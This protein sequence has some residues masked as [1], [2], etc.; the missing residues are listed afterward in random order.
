M[1]YAQVIGAIKPEFVV[2]FN[3]GDFDHPFMVEKAFRYGLLEYFN[4]HMACFY[5]PTKLWDTDL[6]NLERVLKHEPTPAEKEAFVNIKLMGLEHRGRN[7]FTRSGPADT[8]QDGVQKPR[9]P[10]IIIK[11]PTP[12][13]IVVM[14]QP[15]NERHSELLQTYNNMSTLATQRGWGMKHDKVK[16]DPD[17][18]GD[19]YSFQVP[20]TINV[21]AR[22]MFRALYKNPE[23]SSLNWFLQ[24][25]KLDLKEDM[26]IVELFR[27]YREMRDAIRSNNTVQQEALMAD[28]ERVKSYCVTDSES[29]HNLMLK[30]KVVM[31][32]RNTSLLAFT[33]MFD[34]IYRADGMKVR[35]LT[36]HDAAE[37]DIVYSG[38]NKS[39]ESTAKYPG[40]Y[41]VP[42]EKG[43][44]MSKLSIAERV[45]AGKQNVVHPY[46][47]RSDFSRWANITDEDV[48]LLESLVPKYWRDNDEVRAGHIEIQDPD[49]PENLRPLFEDFINDLTGRPTSGLD[50]SSLYPSVM[51]AYNFSPECTIEI[52]Y[53]DP[54]GE[55]NLE[56][57]AD[58]LRA[59][60]YELHSVEFPY[61]DADNVRTIR[62]YT[63]R[64][65][66]D[67]T[68][69]DHDPEERGFGVFPTILHRLFKQRKVIKKQMKKYAKVMEDTG[70]IV[71]ECKKLLQILTDDPAR[72]TDLLIG[73]VEEG[74]VASDTT[75]ATLVEALSSKLAETEKYIV[76]KDYQSIVFDY[77]Y[78]N[79]KQLA[80]KVFMNTFYGE[81]GNKRSSLFM[82]PVSGGIT[83]SGQYNIKLVIGYVEQQKCRVIYGDTDSAYIQCPEITYRD[84]DI[85]YYSGQMTKLEYW[86][87][88]VKLTFDAI[89]IIKNKTNAILR[90]DNLTNF[91][92][93][94]YE[95]VL[96]PVAFLAKKKYY[97]LPHE[98]EINF[99]PSE[100]F[101]KGFDMKK[102]GVPKILIKTCSD[103]MWASLNPDEM[104]TLRGIV[105]D[106]IQEVHTTTWEPTDFEQT[107][108]YKPKK[109]NVKVQTFVRRMREEREIEMKPNERFKYVL[110][111]K[112]AFRWDT[113]GRT[114][115]ATKGDLM[116]LTE[117]ATAEQMEIDLR[118]YM[119]GNLK[120]QFGRLIIYHEEF[121]H[122]VDME[123]PYKQRERIIFDNACREVQRLCERYEDKPVNAWRV[124]SGIYRR[125]NKSLQTN[126]KRKVK[127]GG[128]AFGAVDTTATT[129][130]EVVAALTN[131][132]RKRGLRKLAKADR[133]YVDELI[134]GE[135]ERGATLFSLRDR[136]STLGRKRGGAERLV[137][138]FEQQASG[139]RVE[140]A[141]YLTEHHEV[142]RA[143]NRII[144]RAVMAVRDQVDMDAAN[145]TTKFE[146]ICGE[147]ILDYIENSADADAEEL[148][149]FE[150]EIRELDQLYGSLEALYR[151][152]TIYRAYGERI[153]ERL[154]AKAGLHTTPLNNREIVAELSKD[155]DLSMML[156]I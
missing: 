41:V 57:K 126:L 154:N 80:L 105:E 142:F 143:R 28:M 4:R 19:V 145:D 104:R 62:A 36:F 115:R 97:G 122:G 95:E 120:G 44:Q 79:S 85:Q 136:L 117:V 110:V 155:D 14:S 38:I 39:V 98:E 22:C 91:L 88:L 40:A 111:K 153:I 1:A 11:P 16:L 90:D 6:E 58:R 18:F 73:A 81:S 100:M 52:D 140:L 34:A 9:P 107:A 83:T 27:I 131:H 46:N 87:E 66:Y 25:N 63:V 75:S 156:P 23:Q 133:E 137:A 76:G 33:S 15:I 113:Q 148:T 47:G 130:G 116:E 7:S 89:E 119:S 134:D 51:M 109:K 60:G 114:I 67:P 106:T 56:R 112:P 45:R 102:R 135:L 124:H 84:I 43:M 71:G 29:C 132:A 127:G 24:D 141:A 150:D 103:I 74:L 8:R 49:L 129:G 99:Y 30:R 10:R 128:S 77:D 125:V 138:I 17:T 42:P 55:A 5:Q 108:Q 92:V 69:D 94:A 53:N 3:D 26:P 144:E 48:A 149:E 35:N 86:T 20:G 12:E 70:R 32:A 68:N 21:D 118:Q 78:Y 123:L 72:S 101:L 64:H 146:D 93:V 61:G 13:L 152:Q 65:T 59:M 96:W 37:R 147:D 54:N 31:D 2:G 139:K 121:E 82:L 151:K 50:F